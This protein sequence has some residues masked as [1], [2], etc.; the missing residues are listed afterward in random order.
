MRKLE[1]ALEIVSFRR[2][3]SCSAWVAVLATLL[4]VSA[5]AQDFHVEG[6]LE[7]DSVGEGN[8]LS[9][10]ARRAFVVDV[11]AC[12]WRIRSRA[13]D[14]AANSSE[15][16]LY[17]EI[18]NSFDGI[19]ELTVYD[20]A[21]LLQ[22][23]KTT[24]SW[25]GK[26]AELVTNT[27]SVF[28]GDVPF[29]DDSFATVPWLAYASSCFFQ[30]NQQKRVKKFLTMNRLLFDNKDVTV[31]LETHFT[32]T[33]PRLPDHIKFMNEGFYYVPEQDGSVNRRPLTAPFNRGFE[34]GNY[35]VEQFTRISN[36]TLP[37]AFK[38]NYFATKQDAVSR[39][40]RRLVGLIHGEITSLA[41]A[42]ATPAADSGG[43][44][45]RVPQANAT[46]GGVI[47]V[48]DQRIGSPSQ[49]V[50]YFTTG[51][52]YHVNDPR[53]KDKEKIAVLLRRDRASSAANHRLFVCLALVATTISFACL[54]W[55][56][57]KNSGQGNLAATN[58]HRA[59][60][61]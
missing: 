30:T 29:L 31:P 59:R 17:I 18:T 39:D 22:T 55:Y 32:P 26:K 37:K 33:A 27:V 15:A 52:V 50:T 49:R 25:D 1:H 5:I 54:A 56:A 8:T 36:L 34:E 28:R 19:Y 16:R 53:L 48:N 23:S 7:Y 46:A 2:T 60:N 43:Q 58:Q 12:H 57:R 38:I 35:T 61:T 21:K 20:G 47:Y 42:S 44:M 40:D 41:V 9:P 24:S 45:A 4:A 51:Q 6:V 13:L 14:A 3:C 10:L 11:A